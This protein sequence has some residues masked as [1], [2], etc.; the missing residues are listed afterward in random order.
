MVVKLM[1]FANTSAPIRIMNSME[2]V[3]A[4]S[5]STSRSTPQLRD[6]REG[7]HERAE[8]A[9]PRPFGGREDPRVDPPD[10]QGEER[11]RPRRRAGRATGR[12]TTSASAGPDSGSRQI[13]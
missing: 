9:D 12:P 8:R 4:D 6:R 5:S 3:R 11:Q 1:K 13:M 10:R 7:E 2:V